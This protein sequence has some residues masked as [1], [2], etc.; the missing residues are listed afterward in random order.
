MGLS[1]KQSSEYQKI[2]GALKQINAGGPFRFH[3][4]VRLL[5]I[6]SLLNPIT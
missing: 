4:V 1:E 5:N 6:E 2:Q 3:C